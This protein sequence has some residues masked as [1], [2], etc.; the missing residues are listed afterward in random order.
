[1]SWINLIELKLHV[2]TCFRHILASDR[3]MFKKMHQTIR[4]AAKRT[5]EAFKNIPG[6]FPRAS[7]ANHQQPGGTSSWAWHRKC[8]EECCEKQRYNNYSEYDQL[9][10]LV[11]CYLLFLSRYRV[12]PEPTMLLIYQCD[13]LLCSTVRL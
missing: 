5:C 8:F 4:Q 9:R 3:S 10:V 12:L 7:S 1:M 13:K 2:S 11:F 6:Q